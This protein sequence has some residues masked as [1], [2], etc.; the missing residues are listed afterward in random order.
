MAEKT[1]HFL[2]E[3]VGIFFAG[4]VFEKSRRRTAKPVGDP[5]M[6]NH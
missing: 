2:R 3:A 6:S 4:A 5:K 1:P